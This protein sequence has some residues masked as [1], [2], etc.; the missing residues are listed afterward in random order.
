ML[1]I[2]TFRRV[3]AAGPTPIYLVVV[4]F[5]KIMKMTLCVEVTLLFCLRSY[6]IVAHNVRHKF[7]KNVIQ[8]FK[9]E[10]TQLDTNVSSIK[11][12]VWAPFEKEKDIE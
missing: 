1:V 5:M 3:Q 11:G 6:S 4:A 12:V 10:Y 8:R 9:S 2:L 7:T